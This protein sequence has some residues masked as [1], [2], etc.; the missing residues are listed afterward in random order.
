MVFGSLFIGCLSLLFA[1]VDAS[2]KEDWHAPAQE[3]P[4]LRQRI[5][6]TG[7]WLYAP[8]SGHRAPGDLP[9]PPQDGWKIY[10]PKNSWMYSDEIYGSFW[11]KKTFE[12]AY[13]F[14]S[15][16]L[17]LGQIPGSHRVYLNGHLIGGADLSETLA[18]YPFDSSYLNL[19]A[20]NTLLVSAR[21]HPTLRPGISPLPGVGMFI[22][23][24]QDVRQTTMGQQTRHYVFQSLKLALS[25]ALFL[26]TLGFAIFRRAYRQYFYASLF[27][28]LGSLYL[29]SSHPWFALK[30]DLP[31]LRLLQGVALALS[32]FTFCS[33]CLHLRRKYFAEGINNGAALIA[34]GGISAWFLGLAPPSPSELTL[35]FRSLVMASLLY[36][37]GWIA[38]LSIQALYPRKS[39]PQSRVSQS[40][41]FETLFVAFGMNCAWIS[42]LT[43]SAGEGSAW[44][45]AWLVTTTQAT[46]FV[47]SFLV[48][49]AGTLDKNGLPKAALSKTSSSRAPQSLHGLIHDSPDVMDTVVTIQSRVTSFLKANRST[50]YLVDH[51]EGGRAIL[52]VAYVLAGSEIFSRVHAQVSLHEGIIGQACSQRTPLLI[53]D[54][55]QDL[56]VAQEE[57]PATQDLAHNSMVFP[58]IHRNTLLGVLTFSN[59][60]EDAAFTQDAYAI[61]LEVSNDLAALLDSRQLQ[62]NLRRKIEALG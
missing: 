17:V 35:G 2:R 58:L 40:T 24:I 56:R 13:G 7:D 33:A 26:G 6:V 16:A 32:P 38:I 51:D 23:D 20:S 41:T 11:Y 59:K 29:A 48:I 45:G 22:G 30:L 46:P 62:E 3:S 25:I 42:F 43:L 12:A 9:S 8:E 31:H 54:G 19:S 28:L 18:F 36:A 15:P 57:D 21:V 53:K 27:L 34:L 39:Q 47:F 50:L 61:A 44:A 55:A 1:S 14:Q 49:L 5:D 4:S 52:K 10:D 37:I 60:K